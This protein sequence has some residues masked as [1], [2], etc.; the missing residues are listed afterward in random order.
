MLNYIFHLRDN[1]MCILKSTEK[2]CMEMLLTLLEC[3]FFV[4]IDTKNVCG[5]YR[6][7]C[8]TAGDTFGCIHTASYL[9]EALCL[10]FKDVI[11]NGALY[12]IEKIDKM[13][14]KHGKKIK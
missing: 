3:N 7:A 4:E 13:L 2:V 12:Q 8:R 10:C 9:F 6:V 1:K 5:Y 11:E 14:I